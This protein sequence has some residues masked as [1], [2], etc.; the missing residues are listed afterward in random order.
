MQT[1]ELMTR[2]RFS[3]EARRECDAIRISPEQY[4]KWEQ[5]FDEDFEGF[6][7]H[8]KHRYPGNEGDSRLLKFYLMA[9]CKTYDRYQ[10]LH[11][12]DEVFDETFSDLTIWSEVYC[13]EHGGYGLAEAGWLAKSVKMQLFRLG[14]LQFEPMLLEEELKGAR[15]TI[16]KGTPVLNVHIPAGEPLEY[17]ACLASFRQAEQFAW[18]TV[19]A[20][21]AWKEEGKNGRRVYICDS[22]LLAPELQKMLK[23]DSNIIKFQKLFDVVRVHHSFLQA[24]QR[25]FP[26][27][28]EDKS[29]YPENTALQRNLK[30]Y[31]LGGKEPGIGIGFIGRACK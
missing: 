22:W 2:I 20:G 8:W 17:E 18:G 11:L 13:Q 7:S 3:A 15:E 14:R 28:L 5:L 27:V 26:A 21:A 9:G 30:R 12:S 6:I 31:L 4:Q 24:E 1:E 25:V 23:P 19:T 10:E 29:R 16:P